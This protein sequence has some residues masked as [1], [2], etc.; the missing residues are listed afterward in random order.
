VADIVPVQPS[1]QA[2]HAFYSELNWSVN[3]VMRVWP[4]IKFCKSA[5]PAGDMS[6]RW[7]A[8]GTHVD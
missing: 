4:C 7:V 1:G 6:T 2:G 3:V 5:V 8:S